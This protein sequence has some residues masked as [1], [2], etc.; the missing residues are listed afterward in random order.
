MSERIGFEEVR[1][2]DRI[3]VSYVEGSSKSG[4]LNA[5]VRRSVAS[6]VAAGA[7]GKVWLSED[8]HVIAHVG[9]PQMEIYRLV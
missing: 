2:G 6:Q 1:V 5:G 8:G 9:W 7:L 4:W 3:R